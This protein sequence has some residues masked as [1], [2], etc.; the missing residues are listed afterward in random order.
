MMDFSTWLTYA[1][2]MT[3]IAYT[4]GPMTLFS[5][6]SS[7]KNGFARTLP[8]IA[9][10][11][12]AYLVQMAVVYLGL[13]VV[14]QGSLVIF[15]IIKWTGVV[16]LLVLAM[17]NWRLAARPVDGVGGAGAVSSRRQYSLGFL[18]GMSNPKSILVFTVLF[19]QFID[20]A[21]YTA[22]FLTLAASFAVLQLSSAVAYA[23]FGTRVFTWMHRK[24]LAHVQNR[25]TAVVL[26]LAGGLL[27]VSRK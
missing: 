16:Y 9:G 13:G 3:A 22:D 4:P 8:A 7:V 17:R 26:F 19:P 10:G 14:V 20:P 27:A 18:T 12:S 23:L 2:L 15:N 6:S 5:M 11:S 24:G 1:V 21:R 25:V